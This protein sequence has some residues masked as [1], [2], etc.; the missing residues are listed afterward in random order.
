MRQSISIKFSVPS[1]GGGGGG[2]D[3]SLV[4]LVA[5]GGAQSPDIIA[6]FSEILL[7]I[8]GFFPLIVRIKNAR[9]PTGTGF[10]CCEFTADSMFGP[11]FLAR[12]LKI[13]HSG[14]DF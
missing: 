12:H 1:I 2:R 8:A 6:L 3:G 9:Q 11:F 13:L 4:A 10:K 5:S 14:S 7:G